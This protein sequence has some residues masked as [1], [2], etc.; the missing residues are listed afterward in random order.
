MHIPTVVKQFQNGVNVTIQPSFFVNAPSK[1]FFMPGEKIPNV[2]EGVFYSEDDK[3]IKLKANTTTIPP[4]QDIK[5]M[6]GGT[7]RVIP[8][9]KRLS[10]NFR[11]AAIVYVVPPCPSSPESMTD[12]ECES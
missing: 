4:K 5:K 10:A 9:A 6:A 7:R 12:A 1:V 11:R 3:S 2:P 8:S